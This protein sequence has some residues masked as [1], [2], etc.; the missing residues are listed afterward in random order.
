MIH[1]LILAYGFAAVGIIAAFIW[2][3]FIFPFIPVTFLILMVAYLTGL[4]IY[5]GIEQGYFKFRD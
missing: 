5:A 1:L 2:L 4:A 3:I